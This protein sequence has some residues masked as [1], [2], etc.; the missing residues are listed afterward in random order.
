MTADTN[1]LLRRLDGEGGTKETKPKSSSKDWTILDTIVDPSSKIGVQISHRGTQY[2]ATFVREYGSANEARYS[3]FMNP[4][5][6]AGEAKFEN[7]MFSLGKA[8]RERVEAHR[9][10][11]Q[12]KKP[13][14]TTRKGDK[15][16]KREEKKG[17]QGL[18]QLA[19]TDANKA[20][21]DHVGKTA[22]KKGK[23]S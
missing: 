15:G 20:G 4:L 19:K 6:T 10:K 18:S 22:R 23:S 21:H 11:H 9:A 2:N 8:A 3:K 12:S 13:K 16:K 14:S 17:A 1:S 5:S 7:I